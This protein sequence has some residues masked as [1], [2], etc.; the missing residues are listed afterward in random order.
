MDC[1]VEVPVWVALYAI[2]WGLTQDSH[3]NADTAAFAFRI[4]DR[5][6]RRVR[7]QIRT[8]VEAMPEPRQRGWAWLTQQTPTW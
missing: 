3:A 6:P 5:L 8:E 2:R 1:N 7:D 4:W